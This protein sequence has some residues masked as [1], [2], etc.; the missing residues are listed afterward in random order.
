M[1]NP[2]TKILMRGNCS[3]LSN[4]TIS[5]L[6]RDNTIGSNSGNMIFQAS[7]MRALMKK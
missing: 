7:V 2:M 1:E 4:P 6:I 5:E 3:P